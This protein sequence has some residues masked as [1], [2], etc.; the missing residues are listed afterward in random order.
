MKKHILPLLFLFLSAAWLNAQTKPK[1][2]SST[3][4][5]WYYIQFCKGGAVI[6][7]MGNN[8]NLLTKKKVDGQASQLWKLTGTHD[9]YVLVSKQGRTMNYSSNRF[10]AST[11]S[12]VKFALVSTT[13]TSF[14]P[15]WE[16]K[17]VG[18][19]Q[20][21][22]QYGGAGVDAELGQWTA[23]DGNNPL[24]FIPEDPSR[25]LFP[26]ISSG[27]NHVWYY[28]QFKK[29]DAVLQDMGDGENLKT[30]IP[31][32]HDSQ[33]W[34]VSYSGDN[35]IIESKLGNKIIYSDGFYKTSS[36]GSTLFQV[37]STTN[38]N[39][40]TA[41]ELQ[42]TGTEKCMNQWEKAGFERQLGEWLSGDN[43]NTLQFVNIDEMA[44]TDDFQNTNDVFIDYTGCSKIIK[45][46]LPKCT[47]IGK[48]A[49]A[50]CTVLGNLTF[51]YCTPPVYGKNAFYSPQD[52]N[53]EIENQDNDI[54]S[55]WRDIAEWDA[56]KWKS[57][58][59]INEVETQGWIISV[60]GNRLIISGLM[61]G[62][63]IR[64]FSVS[65]TQQYF[66]STQDGTLDIVLPTG[67]YIVNQYNKSQKIF[68]TK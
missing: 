10:Q 23:G 18:Q 55:K 50:A 26:E 34:K 14:A 25:E 17:R 65:G 36:T 53:I 19:T 43:S 3:N 66:S 41:F 39:Y 24:I 9:N 54:V 4:E 27:T 59:S 37:R 49:F 29:G 60:L 7:D 1:L 48:N 38:K 46:N 64:I 58:S 33:L 61:P 51:S 11:G 30:K 12:S 57:T 15:A 5:F 45:L 42:R 13:N 21:M 16:L 31:R 40:P 62:S 68:I 47:H 20:C 22:N 56:F 44:K 67:F 8:T 35:Y 6:Q 32:K 28:I 52:I 63:E 2:S